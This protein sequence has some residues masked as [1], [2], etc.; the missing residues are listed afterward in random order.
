MKGLVLCVAA[1]LPVL[2]AA[3]F[4]AEAP[5]LGWPEVIADL[6]TERT[7]A[8]TCVGLIKSRGDSEAKNKAE[9]TYVPAKADM[10]GVIAG[11]EIVLAQGGKPGSLPTVRP[12]LVAT[13][14]SLKAICAAALRPLRQT[15]ERVTGLQSFRTRATRPRATG[16]YGPPRASTRRRRARRTCSNGSPITGPT[17]P[18]RRCRCLR[19]RGCIGRTRCRSFST[20]RNRAGAR[21]RRPAAAR[22]TYRTNP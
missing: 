1:A 20:T 3:A 10:D 9:A 15:R 13:A 8:E 5:S 14:S 2:S 11:L 4:G 22:W 16:S 12:S 17:S 7:Q 6:T 21:H 19:F 18:R